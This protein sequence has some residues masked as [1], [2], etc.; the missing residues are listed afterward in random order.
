MHL[1]IDFGTSNTAVSFADA[2]G[3][4]A[5]VPLEGSHTV[6]PSAIFFPEDGA[7][8]LIGR[9]AVE[10][11]LAGD[12]GRLLRSLKS[13][14]GSPLMDEKTVVQ[15]R[16]VSFSE[17]LGLFLAQVVER[18]RAHL[19]G[20]PRHVTLGRPVHFHDT[21]PVRDARAEATLRALAQQ[22]GFAQVRFRHEPIAA[23]SDY[24]RTLRRDVLALV[25]DIGGGTSDF[26]LARLGP[27]RE[28]SRAGAAPVLATAGVHVAGND[29]DSRLDLELVM[30]LLGHRH[31]GNTGKEVP[32][33]VFFDLSTWHLIPLA[34]SRAGIRRAAEL[35]PFYADLRLHRRLMDTVQ[36]G[37]GHRLL[38]DVEGLKIALAAS[39]NA[40]SC[41]LDHL[42]PGLAIE[43]GPTQVDALLDRE[44][45][46]VVDA[47]RACVRGAG[48]DAADID[49]LYLTGGSSALPA[50]RRGLRAAFPGADVVEGDAFGS[51]ALGL[52]GGQ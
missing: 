49:V 22:L 5:L 35:R 40:R 39:P 41:P 30:P 33:P 52:V 43:A 16:L 50:F 31:L 37:L 3:R 18:A 36:Q 26:C 42:E 6:L 47:A 14:L 1:G 27:A 45:R 17:V 2:Q 28:G 4:V 38:S 7:P 44:I 19:G 51:V 46:A 11:Y 48:R 8:P 12:E 21:D 24:E 29:F 10:A 23:A 15:G 34:Q 13:I 32:S 20:V 25:A 9:A